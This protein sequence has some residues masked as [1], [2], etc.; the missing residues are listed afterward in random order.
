MGT[1]GGYVGG[2]AFV[3]RYTAVVLPLLLLVAAF[4]VTQLPSWRWRDAVLSVLVVVGL[5]ASL[6]E[7]LEVRTQAPDVARAI[8]AGSV[9]GEVVAYCPSQLGPGVSRLLPDDRRGSPS[10]ICRAP[11]TSTTATTS[12]TSSR[13][14]PAPSPRRSSSVRRRP[15]VARRGPAATTAWARKCEDVVQAVEA[16]RPEPRSC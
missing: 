10:P 14:I 7:V 12:T 15:A 8:E 3:A 9:A 6:E 5:V 11:G 1:A 16:V 13:A 4:G 2:V